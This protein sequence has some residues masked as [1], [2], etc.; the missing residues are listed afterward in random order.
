MVVY[1][2]IKS[3]SLQS[4]TLYKSN[5]ELKNFTVLCILVKVNFKVYL[6]LHFLVLILSLFKV[7]KTH[8]FHLLR[9]AKVT[10]GELVWIVSN[11]LKLI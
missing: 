1:T 10:W 8:L 11:L 3:A 4:L 9:C 7:E 2:T 5:E 6:F